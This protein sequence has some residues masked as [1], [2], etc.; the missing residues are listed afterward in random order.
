[1]SAGDHETLPTCQ[2]VIDCLPEWLEGGLPSAEEGPLERHLV[3]CPPCGH[4]ARTYRRVGDV[5][6]AA[7]EIRMPEA[8]S[9][10]LWRVLAVRFARGS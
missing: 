2:R 5:A 4:L 6:R 8:A 7:L 1:M 10:R 3:H 9:E